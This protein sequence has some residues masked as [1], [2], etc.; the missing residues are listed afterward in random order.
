LRA[1][2]AFI[3]TGASAALAARDAALELVLDRMRPLLREGDLDAAL[4]GAAADIGDVLAG[5]LKPADAFW[6]WAFILCALAALL[7]YTQW[8][9][10]RRAARYR[11]VTKHLGRLE[12]DV[13][14]ARAARFAATS[15]PIC[16][17]DFAPEAPPPGGEASASGDGGGSSSGSSKKDDDAPSGSGD[18]SAQEPVSTLKKALLPCGHAFCAPCLSRALAAKPACPICRAP[19]DGDG[20]P[21]PPPP[22]APPCGGGGNAVAHAAAGADFEAFQPEL[23]FRLQRLQRLHPDVVTQGMVDRWASRSHAGGFTNDPA[24]LRADPARA[25]PPSGGGG[26]GRSGGGGGGGSGS[27][28]GGGSSSGGGGR[29]GGW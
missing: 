1:P 4:A 11:D 9:A 17:E 21:A 2:Q 20:A 13:A 10:A 8:S 7:V 28:F 19:P 14:R 16:M 12:G 29:G 24:L 23:A 22:P 3:S 18:A 6:T 25:Q 5:R 26:A 15:C 27:L